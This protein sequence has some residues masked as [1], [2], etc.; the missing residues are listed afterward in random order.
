MPNTTKAGTLSRP[1]RSTVELIQQLKDA[2]EPI[3]LT[4]CG[5]V[6]LVIQDETSFEHLLDLIE[7]VETTPDITMPEL[8]ARL[9]SG[10]GVKARPSSL[11]RLLCKAGWTYKKSADGAGSRTRRRR[12][13]APEVVPL[14][15]ALA[16]PAATAAGVHR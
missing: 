5:K 14:D 9:Q 4:I 10:F 16:L 6:E 15:P 11:S 3:V 7:W 2:G 12:Q 1:A 8:A 13:A